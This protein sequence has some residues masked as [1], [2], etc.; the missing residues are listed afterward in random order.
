MIKTYA[1]VNEISPHPAKGHKQIELRVQIPFPFAEEEGETFD[2][3]LVVPELENI[4]V[5]DRVPITILEKGDPR[6]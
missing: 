5:G 1:I 6:P 3:P 2:S 4:K